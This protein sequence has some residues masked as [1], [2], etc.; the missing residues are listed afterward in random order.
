MALNLKCGRAGL[1]DCLRG[2][3]HTM[4]AVHS[5][6][7]LVLAVVR[8]GTVEARLDHMSGVATYGGELLMQFELRES[9]HTCHALVARVCCGRQRINNHKHR[10][11]NISWFGHIS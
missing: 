2:L 5:F 1:H 8:V 6:S 9:V 3:L 4:A 10:I 7:L 11:A